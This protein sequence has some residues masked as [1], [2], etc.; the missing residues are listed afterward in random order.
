MN[1]NRRPSLFA[2]RKDKQV[3]LAD[4]Q[5]K[6]LLGKGSYGKVY[7]IERHSNK[8][9]VYAMKCI[10]KRKILKD[11]ILESAVLEKE[12]MQKVDH[13]FLNELYYVFQTDNKIMYV[14][15]FVRGGELYEHQRRIKRFSEDAA[16]F[17]TV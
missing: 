7:L 5:I 1:K 15:K 8:D 4:F 16:K 11:N 12:I 10:D 9:E 13:P 17:Y 2:K 14:M 3:T 6:K